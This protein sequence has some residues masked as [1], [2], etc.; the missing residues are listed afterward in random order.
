MLFVA[1]EVG[2]AGKELAIFLLLRRWY[3]AGKWEI[4]R[5]DMI[6]PLLEE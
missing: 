4:V 5:K 2:V 3:I 1:G 6:N